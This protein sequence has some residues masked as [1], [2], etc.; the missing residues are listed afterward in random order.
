[1]N[2]I[3]SITNNYAHTAIPKKLT[4]NALILKEL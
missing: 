4:L 3:H 2:I 1:M